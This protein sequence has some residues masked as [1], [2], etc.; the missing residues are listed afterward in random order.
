ME[1]LTNEELTNCVQLLTSEQRESQEIGFAIFT[2]YNFDDL[3]KKQ[4][5]TFRI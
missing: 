4:D 1:Q 3:M 5:K 2:A